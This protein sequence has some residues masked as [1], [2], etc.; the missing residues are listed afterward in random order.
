MLSL[1]NRGRKAAAG[2]AS[3][4]TTPLSRQPDVPA[5]KNTILR[6]R[7]Y[8]GSAPGPGRPL[9]SPDRYSCMPIL[10]LLLLLLLR[11][12]PCSAGTNP[13]VIKAPANGGTVGGTW[14]F[15]FN[16]PENAK[17]DSVYALFSELDYSGNTIA[18]P[19][20]RIDFQSSSGGALAGGDHE[21]TIG[22]LAGPFPLAVD[23]RVKLATCATPPCSLR[24]ID[25]VQGQPGYLVQLY[26]TDADENTEATSGVLFIFSDSTTRPV[27]IAAPVGNGAKVPIGFVVQYNKPE[28][29]LAGSLTVTLDPTDSVAN[30]GVADAAG[31]RVIVLTTKMETQINEAELEITRLSALVTDRGEEVQSVTPSTDLVSGT[32][33]AVVVAYRDQYGNPEAAT[34][35]AAP[36]VEFDGLTEN[37]IITSP[38]A[39]VSRFPAAFVLNFTLPEAAK[40]G[41]LIVL[42]QASDPSEGGPVRRVTF[43]SQLNAQ[44]T[45]V[46]TFGDLSTLASKNVL[47]ASVHNLGDADG[48]ESTGTN[49]VHLQPYMITLRYRDELSNPEAQKTVAPVTFDN[50]TIPLTVAV[51]QAGSRMALTTRVEL[52]IPERAFPGS[53]RLVFDVS[54]DRA[55]ENGATDNQGSRTVTLSASTEEIG[56]HAF[57]LSG[58]DNAVAASPLVQAVNPAI[59]L[60][61]NVYYDLAIGYRDLAGNVEERVTLR[62]MLMDSATDPITFVNP[63]QNNVGSTTVT[64]FVDE[65]FVLQ[66]QLP[67]AAGDALD[68]S[69]NSDTSASSL[70]LV[71]SPTGSDNMDES[72]R[73]LNLDRV[74]K[75]QKAVGQSLG[76]KTV[77]FGALS[78]AATTNQEQVK[79]VNPSIDLVDSVVYSMAF[80]YRDTHGNAAATSTVTGVRFAGATTLAPKL[81]EPVSQAVVGGNFNVKLSLPEIPLAGSLQIVITPLESGFIDDPNTEA[82]TLVLSSLYETAGA[83]MSV[84][85]TGEISGLL[86]KIPYSL[87][88]QS[89]TNQIDLVDGA[90]YS[91]LVKY[92]DLAGN[93]FAESAQSTAVAFAGAETLPAYL[94]SPSENDTL[95]NAFLVNYTLSE[96]AKRASVKLEMQYVTGNDEERRTRVIAFD[97]SFETPGNHYVQMQE[98]DTAIGLTAIDTIEPAVALADGT[99]VQSQV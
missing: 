69:G 60:V 15:K 37:P 21:I 30:G 68:A 65:A 96:R 54:A 98:L 28:P 46:V 43:D 39:T 8:G 70:E 38:V 52:S 58:L 42:L 4:T 82:R 31:K 94:H 18:N 11:P 34:S 19:E 36:G 57:T 62:H 56:T 9:P 23:N 32:V 45:H 79:S 22:D 78:S 26:Y 80:T 3:G 93:A 41:S 50:A 59:P 90:E 48:S 10:L 40:T 81:S 71:I 17:L 20:R 66:V 2:G 49:L 67:E 84:G 44:G 7:R 35:V 87:Y 76:L 99:R 91:F 5:T 88:Y 83:E 51:P 16:L 27:T 73:D 53:V 25:P 47:V 95:A 24:D 89:I 75:F 29:A 64:L 6:T 12:V 86:T 97:T 14:T 77:A 63:D 72:V 13:P 92:Q 55:G 1:A 33:Y 61:H 74:V 85:L